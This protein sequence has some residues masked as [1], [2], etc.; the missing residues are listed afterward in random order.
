MPIRHPTSAAAAPSASPQA[1]TAPWYRVPMLA[2]G[3]YLAVMTAVI[4]AIFVL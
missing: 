1:P 4:I 2:A 3:I